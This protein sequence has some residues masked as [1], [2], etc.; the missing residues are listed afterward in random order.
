MY[1]RA[2]NFTTDANGDLVTNDGHYVVGFKLDSTGNPLT[3]A[4]Q[5]DQ[6]HDPAGLRSPSRS[7]RTAP[8]R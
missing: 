6:D 5:R 3:G 1:T 7:P 2:G 8:C 4:A